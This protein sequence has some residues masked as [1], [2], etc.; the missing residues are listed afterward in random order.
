MPSSP[1][2]A[3]EAPSASD[4][5]RLAA[6][7]QRLAKLHEWD[8]A[9]ETRLDAVAAAIVAAGGDAPPQD[10]DRSSTISAAAAAAAAAATAADGSGRDVVRRESAFGR[11]FGVTEAQAQDLYVLQEHFPKSPT[12]VI[13]AAY[14]DNKCDVTSTLDTLLQAEEMA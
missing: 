2:P 13:M 5:E 1:A 7:Q 8:T 11:D 6:L 9:A 3:P 4:A 12:H 14:N 10:R